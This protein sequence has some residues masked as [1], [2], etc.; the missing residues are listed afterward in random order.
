M[1]AKKTESKYQQFLYNLAPN[2]IPYDRKVYEEITPYIKEELWKHMDKDRVKKAVFVLDDP[3]MEY[4]NDTVILKQVLK[5]FLP[6]VKKILNIDEQHQLKDQ[7]KSKVQSKE[8]ID[9]NIKQQIDL[10]INNK[11]TS[12]G[13]VEILQE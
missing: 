2:R 7:L 4:G 11:H 6:K 5:N 13:I 9:R 3:L 1:V 10:Y 12:G 8:L